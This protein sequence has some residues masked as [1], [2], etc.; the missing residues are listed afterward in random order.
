[1]GLSMTR[2]EM[3][4][5]ITTSSKDNLCNNDNKQY[6]ISEYKAFI[7]SHLQAMLAMLFFLLLGFGQKIFS[8]TFSIDTQSLI[9]VPDSLYGSWFEINRFALVWLKKISGTFWYNN[10]LASFLAIALF[11][12]TATVWAYL[13]CSMTDDKTNPVSFMVP[14]VVSPIMA[15]Q[16]GFLLQAPEICIGLISV[17]ISLMC[18]HNASGPHFWIHLVTAVLFSAFAFS[19]YAAMLTIFV[20]GVAMIFVLKYRGEKSFNRH[21]GN[22]IVVRAGI[23]IIAYGLYVLIN[24]LVLLVMHLQTNPYINDQSRWGKDS[25]DVIVRSLGTQMIRMYSGEGIYYSI[26]FTIIA[27]LSMVLLTY[28]FICRESSFIYLLIYVAICVSPMMMPVLLGGVASI[29]TEMTYPWS[30][31][32]IVLF[33]SIE[34]AHTKIGNTKLVHMKVDNLVSILMVIL[35]GF[36]QGYI[37]NRIFYTES[38]VYNQDV[39]LANAVAN[40]IAVISGKEIPDDPVVFVGAHEVRCNNDCY[41]S[42]QLELVGKSLF[43]VTFST[44]HGTWVKNQFMGTQGFQYNYP[45]EKQMQEADEVSRSMPQW[46]AKGSVL[47]E[48]GY[49]IVKF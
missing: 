39:M 4:K 25:I 36:N 41:T 44:Q 23:C 13:L 12:V 11:G 18:I 6:T 5:S 22:F 40:R 24:K 26:V 9:Q 35:I 10:A 17:A 38:V 47:Q 1:M 27:M 8:N 20:T 15:E 49:I 29:R 42:N 37:T 28:Q 33:I 3:L 31:G 19:L 7:L 43:E 14:I 45:T 21:M 30:F 2:L 48:K 32:F 16:L 46:P 34:L